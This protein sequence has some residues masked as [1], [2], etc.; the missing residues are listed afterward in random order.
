[1]NTLLSANFI[2]AS[3]MEPR[4]FNLDF[5]L[6]H[7]AVLMLIA[8]FALFIILSYVLFNPAREMLQKRKDKIREE[9][10]N[11]AN[12]QKEASDLKSEYT[13][14]LKNIEM[15]AQEILNDA[16]KRALANENKIVAEAKENALKIIER[17][18]VEAELEKRKAKDEVKREMVSIASLM[19][20][21][22]VA[23]SIDTSVQDSL[24]DETLKE[25]G[26]STWLS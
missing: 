10:I 25:I 22:V 13:A 26:G 1:M 23:A 9:L 18:D 8:V 7:D 4:L 11:A 15:E 3:E 24:I 19:A 21:K 5:Q 2:L 16:R 12:D 6:L 14:K 17:A 20:G